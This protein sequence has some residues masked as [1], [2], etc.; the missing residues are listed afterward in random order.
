MEEI[1]IEIL[2][3]GMGVTLGIV[4]IIF[5]PFLLKSLRKTQEI[6]GDNENSVLDTQKSTIISKNIYSPYGSMENFNFVIFQKE[7]GVRIEL[8][9]KDAEQY[10]MM[11]ENDRGILTHKGKKFISFERIYA[12]TDVKQN[13]ETAKHIWRCDCGNQISQSPCPYCGKNFT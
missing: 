7:N 6:Y 11:F 10:K 9:V 3:I 2:R 5:I 4:I 8:A 12:E 1:D 13:A